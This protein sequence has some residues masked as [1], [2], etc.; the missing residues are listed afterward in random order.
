MADC[1]CETPPELAQAGRAAT[2]CHHSPVNH[3]QDA[4]NSL[5]TI[6]NYFEHRIDIQDAFNAPI[7]DVATTYAIACLGSLEEY[8]LISETEYYILTCAFLKQLAIAIQA[9]Q[10]SL[11]LRI[12]E[13]NPDP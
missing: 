8:E 2:L 6:L 5:S 12:A 4:G 1:T 13:E 3:L 11:Y 7:R 9:L 10:I